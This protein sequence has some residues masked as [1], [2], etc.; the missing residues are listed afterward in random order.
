MYVCIL[1]CSQKAAKDKAKEVSNEDTKSAS[2]IEEEDAH[3]FFTCK[4]CEQTFSD[5][6]I[7]KKH[8]ISCTSIIKKYVCSKCGKSY[9]QKSLLTQHFDYRHTNKP[10][11]FVCQ[12]CEKSS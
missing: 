11:Q 12:P 6:D 3:D 2:E 7:Y 1:T 4:V 10:K 9:S 8:K 5:H